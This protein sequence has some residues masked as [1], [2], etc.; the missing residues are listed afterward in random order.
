MPPSGFRQRSTVCAF[1]VK[2]DAAI[3]TAIRNRARFKDFLR[4]AVAAGSLACIGYPT[5]GASSQAI[6]YVSLGDSYTS[7]EGAQPGE[8][9]P[10]VLTAHLREAGKPVELANP[11]RTGFTSADLIE[12][13]L[14]LLDGR[15]VD[16]VTLLIGAN[17]WV[18]GVEAAAFRKNLSTIL[19]RVQQKL[20]N[21][22]RLIVLTI[23][24]FGVTRAGARYAEGR[25]VTKGLAE[26]NE[27]IVAAA[28]A[29]GLAIVDLG[30]LSRAMADDPTLVAPDGLHPSAKEYAA[31]A[32]QV[33]PTAL[34]LLE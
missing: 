19:D 2:V 32:R 16:F 31:W 10:A 34:S 23:P 11:A 7:G 33:L 22:K 27:I 12:R 6:H 18:R 21:P 17:D 3:V 26:F 8:A 24:D 29:R 5:A 15:P 28:R 4:A 14:P 20:A 25:D 9:W 30:P 13:E 1:P